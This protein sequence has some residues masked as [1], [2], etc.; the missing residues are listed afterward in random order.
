[1]SVLNGCRG[2]SELE[3]IDHQHDA[4]AEVRQVVDHGDRNVVEIGFFL[5][6][7][8]DHVRTSDPATSE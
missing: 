3:A 1:M 7:Q 2:R 6:E 8:V 5:S 4:L